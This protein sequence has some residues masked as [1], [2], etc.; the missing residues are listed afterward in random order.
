MHAGDTIGS[1]DATAH[2]QQPFF[3]LHNFELAFVKGKPESLCSIQP[4]SMRKEQTLWGWKQGSVILSSKQ[5][6][7]NT[8]INTQKHFILR[9]LEKAWQI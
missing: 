4:S 2:C 8:C 3:C 1:S 7:I 9:V 6:F 5:I